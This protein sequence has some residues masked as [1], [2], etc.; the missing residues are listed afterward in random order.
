MIIPLVLM[1][2]YLEYEPF[3]K[4]VSQRVKDSVIKYCESSKYAFVYRTKELESI[5]EKIETGRYQK[6]SDIDDFFA[7]TIIVPTIN[8]ERTVTEYIQ[9]TFSI[10]KTTK[11]G[12][13][14][15][16]P[17]AF[18]FD[19][20]RITCTLMKP[21]GIE[22]VGLSIYNILFEI[23]IKSAFEHAWAVSTHALAYKSETVDWKR[24]RLASQIKATV[25]QLDT[26]ILSF[27]K[28][29]LQIT[30]NPYPEIKYKQKISNK[31]SKYFDSKILPTELKP[32]DM[33]R[34]SNNLYT[35]LTKSNNVTD[36]DKIFNIIEKEIK[37][38]NLDKVPRSFSLFQ[39]ISAILYENNMVNN[40]SEFIYHVTSEM[41]DIFPKLAEIKNIFVYD[42]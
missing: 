27:E 41:I 17:E 38:L 35:L 22:P 14:K 4:E 30:E 34:F 25:E 12:Q 26:L 29:A 3:V 8:D 5:A 23:Q 31:F 40:S 10:K 13:V 42:E 37:K 1:Q 39:Y 21:D 18:R 33:S 36:W 7:C 19:T 24:L 11:R 32:K 28:S 6:W 20:T 2:K 9:N 15:K 16:A